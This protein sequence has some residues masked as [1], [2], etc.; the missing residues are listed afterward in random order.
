MVAA[1][2]AKLIGN[3]VLAMSAGANRVLCEARLGNYAAAV[4]LSEELLATGIL[5]EPAIALSAVQGALV[6]LAMLGREHEV[7]TLMAQAQ[8][9]FA[10]SDLPWIQQTWRLVSADALVLVQR[11][12]EARRLARS[13][14]W[15]EGRTE[16]YSSQATGA[17]ARWL[18]KTA[19]SDVERMAAETC[20]AS[21]LGQLDLVDAPDYI[22]LLSL[23]LE[24]GD[25]EEYRTA[26]RLEVARAPDGLRTQLVLLNVL[27]RTAP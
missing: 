5:K 25:S 20:V 24:R 14:V 19:D 3:E 13:A 6:S 1:A 17:Y 2:K 15:H 23:A 9:T 26:L 7:V 22:E 11:H 10:T 8:G 16:M 27:P 12:G 4:A 18:L 21:L